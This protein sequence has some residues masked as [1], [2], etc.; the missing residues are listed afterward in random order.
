[1]SECK[2]EVNCSCTCCMPEINSP[3]FAVGKWSDDDDL[4]TITPFINPIN[5]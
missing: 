1:M 3:G 5:D 2:C 4:K